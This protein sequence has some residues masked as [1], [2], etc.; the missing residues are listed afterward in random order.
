MA[1][2]PSAL[3]PAAEVLASTRSATAFKL[4]ADLPG[5]CRPDKLVVYFDRLDDLRAVAEELRGRLAGQPAHG[6]PFTAAI[7]DDGLLSWGA[8]PPRGV[9]GVRST[10]WRLWIARRLAEYLISA[11]TSDGGVAAWRFALD[12]LRLSG[13]D[14][15][16]WAPAGGMWPRAAASG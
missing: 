16:T 11:R 14:T 4:G 13:V 8:D 2:L 9:D 6:V 7:T 5:L 15:D 1:A 12:R 10:S 3:A